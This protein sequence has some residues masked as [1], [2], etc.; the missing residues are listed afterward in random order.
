M[1][2]TDSTKIGSECIPIFEKAG[3][4]FI[5]IPMAP[6]M[7]LSAPDFKHLVSWFRTL[8][9]P[10]EVSNNLF[11]ATIRLIGPEAKKNVALDYIKRAAERASMIGIKILAFGSPSAKNIPPGFSYN[12]AC[13]QL[14]DL[15]YAFNDIVEAQDIT[16]VLEPINSKESNFIVRGH[17]GLEIVEKLNLNHIKLMIDYYHLCMENEDIAILQKAKHFLW[18]LHIASSKNRLFPKPGDGEDYKRI[19]TI[20][21]RNGYTKRISIEA[22]SKNL[23]V[24]AEVSLKLLRAIVNEIVTIQ[25]PAGDSENRRNEGAF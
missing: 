14:L 11:P 18:H 6:I 25:S 15:L 9:I 13:E 22:Y 19:L 8:K 1:N 10:I 23:P 3:Y 12:C 21:K 2:A 4:D 7:D 16:I 5:E 17:E 20:L 24:D